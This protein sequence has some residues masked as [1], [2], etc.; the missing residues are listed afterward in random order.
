MRSFIPAVWAEPE[1]LQEMAFDPEASFL[2]EPLL[3]LAEVT[4]GKIKHLATLGADQM[5]MVLQG[6]TYI[7]ASVPNV[8]LA[9]NPQLY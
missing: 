3:Q 1:K 6:A 2:G 5:T 7:T 4:A 9:N 8:Y